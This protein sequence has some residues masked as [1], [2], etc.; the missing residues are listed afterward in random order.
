MHAYAILCVLAGWCFPRLVRLFKMSID[1]AFRDLQTGVC[2]VLQIS[3]DVIRFVVLQ[4]GLE[5]EAGSPNR[6]QWLPVL[7]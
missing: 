2:M 4:V 5:F 6:A 3:I 1:F 7:S